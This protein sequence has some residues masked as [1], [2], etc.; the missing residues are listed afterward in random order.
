MQDLPRFLSLI[1]PVEVEPDTN[2]SYLGLP[3]PTYPLDILSL[4]GAINTRH[5]R[6]HR[7]Q[8]TVLEYL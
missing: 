6:K 1:P 3:V 4:F 7:H 5:Y 2:S 8:P